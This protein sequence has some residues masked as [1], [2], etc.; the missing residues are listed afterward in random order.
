[1]FGFSESAD[2]GSEKFHF[3][4]FENKGGSLPYNS[5]AGHLKGAVS[6]YS[7]IFC[8]CF[9]RGK[10]AAA[11]ASVAG[12]Q[13]MAARS[14]ARTASPPKLS[15]ENVV[16]LEQLLFSVALPYGRHYFSSHKMAAKND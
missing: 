16:F 2:I 6:R 12:H 7:L 10:M 3:E 11:H 13:T 5:V 14:A 15:R 9:A 8:S 1:M 4:Q